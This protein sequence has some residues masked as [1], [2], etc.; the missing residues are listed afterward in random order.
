M[1]HLDLLTYA[2]KIERFTLYGIITYGKVVSIYD[3][4]T[5][6]M[7]FVVPLSALTSERNISKTK[8]GICMMCRGDYASGGEN[9]G[10]V[11]MR[12]KCRLNGV[13]AKELKTVV[14]GSTTKSEDGVKA[15][16]ILESYVKDKILKCR[17]DGYDKYGRVLIQLL[18]DQNGKDE[19]LSEH[20]K[21][22]HQEY[23][24]FYDGGEK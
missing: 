23:F 12:M 7:T 19:N 24:K 13:D 9:F 18:I 4:D 6:D 20:L 21:A 3:G 1:N 5:F 22:N 16:E 8:K 15:K 10:S 14:N 2:D 11:L 17:F